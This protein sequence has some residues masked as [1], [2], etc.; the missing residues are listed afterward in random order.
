MCEFVGRV[1]CVEPEAIATFFFASFTPPILSHHLLTHPLLS[2]LLSAA[3][4]LFF[5]ANISSLHFI[6]KEP[7]DR[8]QTHGRPKLYFSSFPLPYLL[9]LL[10]GSRSLRSI[11]QYNIQAYTSRMSRGF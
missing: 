4:A 2:Y 7:S 6:F 1:T 10:V 9:A 5:P 8:E 11:I 3:A